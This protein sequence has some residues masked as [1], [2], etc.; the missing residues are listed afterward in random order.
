MG[1]IGYG[2]GYAR[3]Y[4][5]KYNRDTFKRKWVKVHIMTGVKTNVVT[6]VEIADKHASDT[7]MLPA[8]VEKTAEGFQMSEVSGDK[9]YLSRKNVTAIRDAGALPFIAFKSNSTDKGEAALSKTWRD[10]YYFFMWKHEEFFKVLPQAFE[11]R[12]HILRD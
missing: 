3:W 9:A 2:Y 11:R 6:A 7:K 5:H 10:M 1:I 12:I 8:L 4:D